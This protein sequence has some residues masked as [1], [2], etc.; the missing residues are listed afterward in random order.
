MLS[1]HPEACRFPHGHTRHI[2]VVL[3]GESL[4]AN[5]MLIDFKALKLA[6]T[7]EID[8]FDHSMAI[9]SDDPAAGELIGRYP[10]EA[11]VIFPGQEPTT[12]RIAEFLF[13]RIQ[14]VLRKGF[15]QP[16]YEIAP[17][18]VR[19]ERIR[20]GETPTTWAEYQE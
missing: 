20:V 4:D 19:L 11:L 10:A 3:A 13:H 9:N 12:E 1:R 15:S 14:E 7:Q 16:P 18:K 6:L 5:D 17:G 2:E 8:Q